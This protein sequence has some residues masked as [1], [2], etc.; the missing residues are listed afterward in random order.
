MKS[1]LLESSKKIKIQCQSSLLFVEDEEY[2]Y[3][4]LIRDTCVFSV[5]PSTS[6]NNSITL[7]IDA[8]VIDKCIT[9]ATNKE[10]AKQTLELIEQL[11]SRYRIHIKCSLRCLQ[12]SVLEFIQRMNKPIDI[13]TC[14]V[15]GHILVDVIDR[16]PEFTATNLEE[17]IDNPGEYDLLNNRHLKRLDCSSEYQIT[18]E[19]SIRSTYSLTSFHYEL[20]NRVENVDCEVR[21]L[22]QCPHLSKF[23]LYMSYEI[24]CIESLV[25]FISE[26]KTLKNV[27]FL[28]DFDDS[29]VSAFMMNSNLRKL[30]FSNPRQHTKSNWKINKQL[31]TIINTTLRSLDFT[32]RLSSIDIDDYQIYIEPTKYFVNLQTLKLAMLTI[33]SHDQWLQSLGS[34]TTVQYLSISHVHMLRCPSDYHSSNVFK[35]ILTDSTTLRRLSLHDNFFESFND[36]DHF[37]HLV[38][39]SKSLEILHINSK[40]Y[41]YLISNLKQFEY[42]SSNRYT[43]RVLKHYILIEKISKKM[44]IYL[45]FLMLFL[46]GMVI[47]QSDDDNEVCGPVSL[48]I[49]PED[50]KYYNVNLKGKMC[51]KHFYF[52]FYQSDMEY[53]ELYNPWINREMNV[54][55]ILIVTNNTK[56]KLIKNMVF[57]KDTDGLYEIFIVPRH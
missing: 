42:I 49:K 12:T 41:D 2:D 33:N 54:D 6:T 39:E 14:G 10:K 21:F 8:S 16:F 56:L 55:S 18:K 7:V 29:I 28:H 45:F 37:I 25:E 57:I 19:L 53:F 15:T 38:H 1:E 44:K 4:H 48:T 9:T 3:H 32:V 24:V 50:K 47:C 26:S 34:H 46:I 20:Y 13:E 52:K 11:W 40:K 30:R 36:L 27:V 22:K 17:L 43:G 23:K 51:Y 31:P 5:Y 35:Q